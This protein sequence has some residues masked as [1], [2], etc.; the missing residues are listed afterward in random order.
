MSAEQTRARILQVA[1]A[2]FARG[3]FTGTSVRS[4]AAQAG[5]DQALVH[6]YFGTKKQLFEAAID[7]PFSPSV[8]ADSLV[9][10]PLDEL[11][12]SLVRGLIALWNSPASE[13]I[14]PAIRTLIASQDGP[15]LVQGMIG[16]LVL[17]AIGPR[18]DHPAGSGPLRVALAGSQVIGLML[19]RLVMRVEPVA[20][21]PEEELVRAVGP[22]LQ[23][24]LTGSLGEES[25]A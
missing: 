4:I 14:V 18:I 24:Y 19:A 23:R 21:L 16:Q 6:H 17:E 15:Q 25:S 20:S 11:G 1:R 3:G 8:L 7:L 22:T 12:E 5:V 13:A 10:V 2:A 9:D